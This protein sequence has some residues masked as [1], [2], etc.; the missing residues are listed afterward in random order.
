MDGLRSLAAWWPHAAVLAHLAAAAPTAVHIL[1]RKEDPRAAVGWMGLVWLAPL[2]G[3]CLYWGFGVNRIRR[4]GRAS[5]A[6]RGAP[7]AT[8]RSAG[9]APEAVAEVLRPE[10]GHLVQLAELVGRV[11]GQ[12]LAAGN[13]VELL[14]DGDQAYPAMIAAIDAAERTVSL[15]TYL[16]DRDR[17]GQRFRAS[18]RAAAA[19]GVQVR[20][21]VD[22]VGA[23]YS[24][25][26]MT[27]ALRRDGV[28]VARF[29]RSLLPW[30]FRYY[31]LR[32]H[33]KILVTDGTL[34][35][36]GGMNLRAGHAVREHPRHPVQDLHFRV[37]GPV[38]AQLQQA[39][40]ADWAFTT[41]EKLTGPD[42]FPPLS[43]A[44][45]AVARGVA[46]GPDEDFDKLRLTLLGALTC[47]RR[48]VRILT[49]YFLPDPDLAMG[50]RMTALRGVAVEI[51]LPA[52]GNLRMVQ[53][54][55]RAGLGE[56]LEAG[57]RIFCTPPPFDH[58]KLVVVDGG[59]TLF[60]S[61]N[62][63]PRS[64][65]LNF[66]LNVECYDPGLAEAVSRVFEAKLATARELR[67]EDLA[68]RPLAVRLRDRAFRL[69]SPYL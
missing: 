58:S 31:N 18:L 20:V 57:C 50:L 42:W 51:L 4:R 28:P 48:S 2:L 10:Q 46:D 5:V 67:P 9:A 44:G 33:R 16:F 49:P 32:N 29:M 41:E 38:V 12:P 69:F 3:S 56:L 34:G 53:W 21:L 27:W 19:R 13:R 24:F 47:A 11:T 6:G 15:S 14:V 22:D 30:R 39:F 55:S 61:A 68:R 36:T 63:D 64:L 43:P 25:P 40:A 1:L 17:W 8:D 35:F 7:A 62:W 66:E 26:P 23:R 37:A 45:P 52:Q 59:W 65:V 60:G 54:A